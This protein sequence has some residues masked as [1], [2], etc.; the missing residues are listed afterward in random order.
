MSKENK[1]LI[2]VV[3]YY[4]NRKKLSGGEII[5]L[6]DKYDIWNMARRS[7]FIWHLESPENFVREIDRRI[8]K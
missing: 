1:F 4:R 3:E 5:A 8:Y 6:F 7:Y 2:F